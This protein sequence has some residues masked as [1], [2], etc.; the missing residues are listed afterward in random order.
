MKHESIVDC[1]DRR[2]C[3]VRIL[4][5]WGRDRCEVSARVFSIEREEMSA[6]KRKVEMTEAQAYL[7]RRAINKLIEESCDDDN[8]DPITT[9]QCDALHE[10]LAQLPKGFSPRV[11]KWRAKMDAKENQPADF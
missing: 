3:R 8:P 1:C 11:K 2:R 10:V 6:R 4:A 5:H 7:V 9:R